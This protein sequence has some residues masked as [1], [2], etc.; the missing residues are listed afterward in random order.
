MRFEKTVL[1][2]LVL[3]WKDTLVIKYLGRHLSYPFMKDKLKTLWH[4]KG[5]YEMMSAGFGYLLVKFDLAEDR[6]TV[7]VGGP[8]MIQDQYLAVK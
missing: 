8:W 2:K 1:E 4:L 6:E 5:G 3:P 7:M